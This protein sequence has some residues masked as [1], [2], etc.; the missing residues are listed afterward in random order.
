MEIWETDFRIKY[1]I[2]E[3]HIFHQDNPSCHK[4]I[5]AMAKIDELKFEFTRFGSQRLP[6]V[7]RTK[8][9]YAWQA[10]FIKW[11]GHYGC[12]IADLPGWD[13]QFWGLLL[14]NKVYFELYIIVEHREILL[15]YI[16]KLV[17]YNGLQGV[18]W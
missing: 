6:F 11:R 8:I 18:F 7:S 5:L 4:S 15:V 13:T 10:F 12:C 14:N 2:I 3:K 1:K 17:N 16:P 9:T